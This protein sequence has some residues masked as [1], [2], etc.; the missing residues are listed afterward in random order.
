M[1]G[2]YVRLQLWSVSVDAHSHAGEPDDGWSNACGHHYGQ[3]SDEKYPSIWNVQLDGK[4]HGGC[5][6]R[7]RPGSPDADAMHTG[8]YRS[9]VSRLCDRADW[10]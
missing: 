1:Y 3:C 5:R 2:R 6:N 4:S 10:K 8:H 7:R 9:L